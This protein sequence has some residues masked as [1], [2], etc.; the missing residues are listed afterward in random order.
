MDFS[1]NSERALKLAKQLIQRERGDL[2]VIHHVPITTVPTSFMDS[3]VF[4]SEF[5]QDLKDL[6]ERKMQDVRTSCEDVA[7]RFVIEI[8]EPTMDA[9]E[10]LMKR[11]EEQD[12]FHRIDVVVCGHRGGGRLTQLMHLGSVANYLAMYSPCSLVLVR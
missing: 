10:A 7:G 4:T 3:G 8:A 5:T 6:A 1:E 9:R 2:I 11:L 12:P